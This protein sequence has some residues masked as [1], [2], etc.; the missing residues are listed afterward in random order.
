MA[1]LGLD[2]IGSLV[3]DAGMREHL[4]DFG[5]QYMYMKARHEREEKELIDHYLNIALTDG[6]RFHEEEKEEKA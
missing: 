5:R 6:I 4:D 3:N 2:V 1:N